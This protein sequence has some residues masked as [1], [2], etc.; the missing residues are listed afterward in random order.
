MS[1]PPFLMARCLRVTG[2]GGSSGDKGSLLSVGLR[3]VVCSL[4]RQ[5]ARI[6]CFG[7][8]TSRPMDASGKFR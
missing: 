2:V 6:W 5:R 4:A 7:K 1:P 3:E 8:K